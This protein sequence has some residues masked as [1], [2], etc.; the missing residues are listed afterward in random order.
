M[1]CDLHLFDAQIRHAVL[2]ELTVDRIPVPKQVTRCRLP[3]ERFSD[4]LGGP[5]RSRVF[6]DIK[7][8]DLATL[9][10]QHDEDEQHSAL[11]GWHGEEI[12][13]DD[14]FDMVGQKGPPRG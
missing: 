8:H 12:T 7:M 10:S 9:V 4:L 5:L 6:G 1:G 14:I 11:N 3:W 2:E 13:G